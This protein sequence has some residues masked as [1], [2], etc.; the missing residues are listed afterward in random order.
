MKKYHNPP[1]KEKMVEMICQALQTTNEQVLNGDINTELAGSTLVAVFIYQG[2]VLCFNV[3]DSRAICLQQVQTNFSKPDT[4]EIKLLPRL[5]HVHSHEE[6]EWKVVPLS[7][8]Q[9]PDRPD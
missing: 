8:D 6:F 3:G 9:K 4:E 7:D 5:S 1:E 2:R